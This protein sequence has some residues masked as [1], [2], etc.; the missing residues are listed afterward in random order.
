MSGATEQLR[1]FTRR[2][3]VECERTRR[4]MSVLFYFLLRVWRPICGDHIYQYWRFMA[5]FL[6]CFVFK[7]F[8]RLGFG[9]IFLRMHSLLPFSLFSYV[10]VFNYVY[11]FV[12]ISHP[13]CTHAARHIFGDRIVS[14][15]AMFCSLSFCLNLVLSLSMR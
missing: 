3:G 1:V 12:T 14:P 9:Y 5:A 11:L 2:N 7:L 13:S 6:L 8:V 10:S 4:C 15:I